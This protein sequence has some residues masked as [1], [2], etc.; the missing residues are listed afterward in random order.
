M[1]G[2]EIFGDKERKEVG[3]VLSTGVLM[4][5][6]F[7]GARNGHFKALEFEKTLGDITGS[8]FSH[9]CAS[10]TAALST[11]MAACGIG[12]GHE[13]I[14]PPFTFVASFEAVLQAGAI[15]VFAEIDE[16]LCLNPDRLAAVLTP[17][18]R[19]VVPVHMC[20]AMAR[21]DEIK[22]FCEKNGL[23]L[24]EDAC[25]ALGGTFQG[26]HLGSFG[27][28]GCFSF[29]AVKTVTC[30]EGGAVITDDPRVYE[31]CHQYADH[32]HDHLGGPDRG[33]DDHPILGC[34]YRISELNAA[35]GLAQLRKL[36]Q[37]L[38][39]QR[40]NKQI[41]K[42]AMTDLPGISFR[43]L[44]D[45]FGDSA[46]FLS[47]MLP[48]EEKARQAGQR[49]SENGVPCPYWY[50][51][52]WHYYRQWHQL[53]KMAAAAPMA[54]QLC[55]HL[56]DYEHLALPES[57]AIMQRTLSMQ[58][59]LSWSDQDLEQRIAAIKTSLTA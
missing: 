43:Y 18:T 48:T 3:D 9:L 11:A 40:R 19:A 5:Y 26:K 41:L 28:A 21:I 38:A 17:R 1:P 13:V 37:I 33:A 52:N 35:V 27:L 23:A 22:D 31:K 14:I 50:A 4:R 15:P 45:P 36:D 30:G 7:E 57:D 29:D 54:A 55:S 34:N 2:F 42:D 24:L 16:T 6:G 8:A 59:M 56:P 10:G 46:T 20:G 49:L 25:Q 47:F 39:T 44:P 12:A 51:N 58:I 32:G 53:K